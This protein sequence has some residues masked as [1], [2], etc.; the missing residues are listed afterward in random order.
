MTQPLGFTVMINNLKF[1]F[2]EKHFHQT[3]FF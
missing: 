3:H 2:A 1:E